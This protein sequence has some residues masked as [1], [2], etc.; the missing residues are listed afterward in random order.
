MKNRLLL[1]WVTLMMT[2]A[3]CVSASKILE[4][5]KDT[6]SISATADGMSSASSAREKAFEAARIHCASLGKQFMLVNES[7]ARTRM[8]IDT[9]VTITF[10]ALDKNDPEYKRPNVQQVPDVV[11]Q[12]NRK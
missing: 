4:V 5:G 7:V 12:D 10:R 3:G 1:F 9:T 6:F 8:G 2:L 11:I